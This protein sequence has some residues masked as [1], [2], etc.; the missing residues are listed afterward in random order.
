MEIQA[1]RKTVDAC[2]RLL[3]RWS[4]ILKRDTAELKRLKAEIAGWPA[5][6]GLEPAAAAR[7]AGASYVAAVSPCAEE[8]SIVDMPAVVGALGIEKFLAHCSLT[9]KALDVLLPDAEARGLVVAHQTGA[10]S[11]GCDRVRTSPQRR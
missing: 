8:R 7:Y 1:R 10:R 11:V 2:G 6:D 3:E 9:L 4:A 5:A